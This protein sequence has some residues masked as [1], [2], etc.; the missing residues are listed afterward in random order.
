MKTILSAIIFTLAS[1]LSE[2]QTVPALVPGTNAINPRGLTVFQDKLVFQGTNQAS[3]KEPWIFSDTGTA[4]MLTD[5]MPGVI[6]GFWAPGDHY[7]TTAIVNN[8]LYFTGINSLTS[9]HELFKWDGLAKKPVLVNANLYI[10]TPEHLAALNNRLYFSSGVPGS[11]ND[12]LFSYDPATS[13]LAQLSNFITFSKHCQVLRT[14]VFN[15]K[16]VFASGDNSSLQD[17]LKLYEYDPATSLI[18]M[19]QP[20]WTPINFLV[21]ASK[22]YF[23]SHY[24][25]TKPYMGAELFV[26]DGANSPEQLTNICKLPVKG[27]SG[28]AN[29]LVPFTSNLVPFKNKIY[30]FARPEDTGNH[31]LMAYDITTKST[32]IIYDFKTNNYHPKVFLVY[33][34]KLYFAADVYNDADVHNYL[35]SYDG[36]HDP[37]VVD[38]DLI[39]PMEAKIY[40]DNLYFT[41]IP[42]YSA[43]N[44]PLSLYRY[45]DIP[46]SVEKIDGIFTASIYPNPANNAVIISFNLQQ[47]QQLSLYITDAAGR[48]V[49]ELPPANYK[50]GTQYIEMDIRNIPAGVYYCLLSGKENSRIWTGKFLKE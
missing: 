45:N 14:T 2:A 6:S 8:E 46:V 16:I 30:F 26:Y 11:G 40:N 43:G 31:K 49:R 36:I 12:Q 7:V 21:H 9:R 27:Y 24:P 38:W 22:L 34:D 3:G 10:N 13:T 47:E 19:L 41:A 25:G 23:T 32:S 35:C 17:S 42:K 5:L 15:N 37:V 20:S 44:T 28:I 50:A 39:N 4:Y 29:S 48:T 18:N 33:H 1:Q